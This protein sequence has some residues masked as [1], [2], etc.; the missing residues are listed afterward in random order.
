MKLS[1]SLIL[2]A[3]LHC[4]GGQIIGVGDGD[5]GPRLDDGGTPLPDA[6]GANGDGGINPP[7]VT[8]DNPAD[9]GAIFYVS[10]D[11]SDDNGDGSQ[12][13]PWASITFAI[14]QIPDSSTLL[15]GPGTYF[16]RVRLNSQ[17]ASGVVIRAQPVYQARLRNN[18]TV[19]QVF[20]GRGITLSGFDIAHDGDGA[21][22]LVVHIDASGG[23]PVDR[24]V[25]R[26]NILH[27]SYN[28][29]I[30]KING[31]AREIIVER[32]VF[33][34]QEGSD[35]H[36]DINGVVDIVVQDNVFFNDYEASGRV[37]G[38]D[39]SSFIVIKDSNGN[40]D[41]IEGAARIQVRRNVLLNWQGGAGANFI[42]IGEDGN[43]F[44]EG[45]NINIEN[46][47][48]VGNSDTRVRAPL[49]IKGGRDIRFVNNTVVG[50][51]PG[52]A[53]A[54]RF[55]QEGSNPT[56]QNISLYNNIWSDPTGTMDDFS[57]TPPGETEN[58]TIDNNLYYNGGSAIPNSGN[59]DLINPSDDSSAIIGDPLLASAS[60]Q[61]PT[62]NAGGNR[63][64]DGSGDTC[65]AFEA[66]V[67]RFAIPAPG[68]PAIGAARTD[69]APAED[70]LGTPRSGQS[71]IGAYEPYGAPTSLTLAPDSRLGNSRCAVC[72]R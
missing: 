68:S 32:N 28:N 70:I 58:F 60:G 65:S 6:A 31:G 63:F 29:D 54:F 33:Y 27:D 11:G 42:L 37:N 59:S 55:N 8:C 10:E 53:F 30:V 36:I 67:T 46:N 38:E 52:D 12:A 66:L 51:M 50:N 20:E 44:H 16:G 69:M 22:A 17:F 2:L 64:A 3:S 7:R 13:S 15:V 57:D 25:L 14:R 39:T 47:L 48:L 9:T 72:N 26:N 40:G 49:G 18:A 41:G 61:L 4:S 43:P 5:G 62:W 19:I 45:V 24:I 23:A 1:L 21:G 71:T 35:E 34:N 56:N